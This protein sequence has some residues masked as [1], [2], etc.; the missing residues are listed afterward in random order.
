MPFKDS[1]SCLSVFSSGGNVAAPNPLPTREVALVVC[2]AVEPKL[3][4]NVLY[5]APS[6]PACHGQIGGCI[7]D[8]C[9][10]LT[11]R[12]AALGAEVAYPK[13]TPLWRRFSAA[14]MPSECPQICRPETRKGLASA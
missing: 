13:A 11:T 7:L 12:A 4:P 2:F 8:G 5:P 14:H 9:A 1:P 3:V 10:V 6:Q